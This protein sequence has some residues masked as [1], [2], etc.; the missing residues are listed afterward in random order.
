M[1]DFMEWVF[2]F[3]DMFDEGHLRE[4]PTAA[5]DELQAH[6]AIHEDNH[7]D[8]SADAHPIRHMYQVMWRKL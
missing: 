1:C 4:D 8:I 5:R 2:F 3:D 7:P 6:L